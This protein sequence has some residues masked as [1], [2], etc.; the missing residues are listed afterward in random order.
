M[1]NAAGSVNPIHA[2]ITAP[3]VVLP[4]ML[5]RLLVRIEGFI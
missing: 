1:L 2:G 5:I 3:K 4:M